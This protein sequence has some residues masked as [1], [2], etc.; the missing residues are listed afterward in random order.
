VVLSLSLFT[1][2]AEAN[3]IKINAGVLPS[4]WYSSLN[5]SKNDLVKIY[6]G[7]QNHSNVAF[8]FTANMY[9]DDKPVTKTNIIS[10]PNTLL[11]IMVP[12]VATAG[13]HTIQLKIN[14]IT[15]LNKVATTSII[16]NSLLSSESDRVT[17]SVNQ[18]I[19]ADDIKTKITQLAV[20]AVDNLDNVADD[21]ANNIE[22]LKKT[23]LADGSVVKNSSATK[24]DSEVISGSNKFQDKNLTAT[25]NGSSNNN[26][27]VSASSSATEESKNILTGGG[28][29][30][31]T[32]VA[33]ILDSKIFASIYNQVLSF[34]IIMIKNWKITLFIVLALI[35]II[36]F[37]G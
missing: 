25:I 15:S 5:I 14:N 19:T 20:D 24:S 9:I 6:S 17:I 36:K 23:V 26:T 28:N 21:L 33:S 35:V 12:W 3:D 22:S 37:V 13:S 7:I 16:A 4:I 10:S 27:K 30:L 29:Q 34:V 18:N 32:V 1:T 2:N 11:E 8:S 31:A